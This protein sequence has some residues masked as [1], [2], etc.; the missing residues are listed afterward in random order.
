MIPGLL[1]LLCAALFTAPLGGGEIPTR[2]LQSSPIAL[3]PDESCVATANQDSGSISVVDLA[4]GN[5]IK[6][7]R[8]G[9]EPRTLAW[10][11]DGKRVYVIC[12]RSQVLSIVDVES[13]EAAKSAGTIPIE[14]QP[15]GLLLL[16]GGRKA[17]VSRYAGGYEGKK[18]HPGLVT[19]VDLAAGKTAGSVAVRPRP[20]ALAAAPD[21]R[22]VYV[23]HYLQ[24][25]GNGY[26]TE[27]DPEELRVRREFVLRE[28]PDI[29]D[30]RGGVFNA[31]SS[32]AL[33]PGGRRALVTGMHANAR[34]GRRLNGQPLSHKTTVQAAL[35]LLDLEG[36][37]EILEA[38]MLSSFMGQAVAVPV[39][40]AFIGEGEHFL[41]LYF[42]SSD[43]KILKYNER[44][45][46]A[47][48]SLRSLPAGPSGVA[49]S[50][51]QKTA[52]ILSRWDR[53][54]SRISLE[55]VRNPRLL[56]TIRVSEEPWDARRLRGARLFHNT[57]DHRMTANRWISCGVCHLDG[58]EISDGLLWDLTPEGGADK[59]SN[60]M[61]LV[62]LA[63]TAPPFFHRGLPDC[64]LAL[65]R[66]VRVFHQ[67]SGFLDDGLLGP[68]GGTPEWDAPGT[69]AK[70]LRSVPEE[71]LAINAY[72]RALRP[73][74]S[75][76][77]RGNRPRKEMAEAADR[78]RVLFFDQTVGCGR[79][80][81][82]PALTESGRG[83][84]KVALQD[85]LHDV[86]T[87]KKLDVPALL[88]LWDTA[89]YLHDGRAATLREVLVEHNAGDRH[90]QT[91]QLSD[92][93]IED[94]VQFLLAPTP[95]DSE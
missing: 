21:G 39:Q 93:Q 56:E 78:G 60:T 73:R 12:Q 84:G 59:V 62:L 77:R 75:P 40:V 95:E 36:G 6:E 35:R 20:W 69:A 85:L 8:V 63:S 89:P 30:G 19:L 7:I 83:D 43:F 22:S 32:I 50:R 66:F 86:G 47:E 13:I 33:H 67:G 76:H 44:G 18:Y 74:P 54:I 68:E 26:V 4:G 61:D 28:D 80:H 82:G 88:H 16:P 31:L 38:R 90:G 41:D 72:M 29:R 27:I 53:S 5:R 65:E 24:I 15:Y 70:S 79:C 52:F 87:G 58:G 42:A 10:S 34:R 48:R 45:R 94:L 25:D 49:I 81:N 11:P 51:D 57:R 46:V 1:L 2:A 9:E 3:S 91:S 92:G 23:T 64:V 71:W 14:G 55:D 17:C 37:E